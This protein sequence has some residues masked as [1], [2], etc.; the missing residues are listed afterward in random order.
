MESESQN[1]ENDGCELKKRAMNAFML[2]VLIK[3]SYFTYLLG[4]LIFSYY[5]V[6]KRNIKTLETGI[7]SDFFLPKKTEFKIKDI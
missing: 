4:F 3:S 7:S 2:F 5:I 6:I 1:L